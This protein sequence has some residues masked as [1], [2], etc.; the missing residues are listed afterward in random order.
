MN[1]DFFDEGVPNNYPERPIWL[2]DN[3]WLIDHLR[4]FIDAASRDRVTMP[5]RPINEKT[6]PEFYVHD[7]NYHYRWQLLEE[8]SGHFPVFILKKKRVKRYQEPYEGATLILESEG[9]HIIRYWLGLPKVRSDRVI[10]NDCVA[11]S[12]HFF[13]DSGQSLKNTVFHFDG[14]TLKEVVSAFAKIPSIVSQCCTLRELSASCFWGDSKFLD[15][16]EEL[17]N[18]LCGDECCSLIKRHLLINVYAPESVK[19]ILIIENQDTFFRLVESRSLQG[20]ALVYGSGFLASSARGLT[21][22][23]R[24]SYLSKSSPAIFESCWLQRTVPV[25]FWGDLDY[26]GMRILAALNK[27]FLP[28]VAWQPGYSALLKLLHEGH[29]HTPSAAGK[30]NQT[31][32]MLTGCSY[33]DDVI[34]PSLRACSKFVDQEA[35]FYENFSVEI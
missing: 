16:K 5:R 26:S 24:F 13:A 35:A 20:Y 27:N 23:V 18:R 15:N 10:W 9:E 6:F 7:D 19:S 32:P 4:W 22:S 25:Y 21:D 2:A 1:E 12:S 31:D 17:V 34:L 3:E 14:K 11:E 28:V 29:A 30:D 33:A 8:L